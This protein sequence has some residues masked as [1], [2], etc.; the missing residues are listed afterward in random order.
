MSFTHD[1]VYY[2]KFRNDRAVDLCFYKNTLVH[3]K[4]GFGLARNN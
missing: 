3:E 2:I 4:Y 1:M